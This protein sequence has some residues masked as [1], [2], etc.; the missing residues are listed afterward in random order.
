MGASH[1]VKRGHWGLAWIGAVVKGRVREGHPVRGVKA[2]PGPVIPGRS[3]S[4]GKT[5]DF[6]IICD[7][8]SVFICIL[9]RI[10]SSEV[11][12]RFLGRW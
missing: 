10:P 5:H 3:I 1:E 7:D 2:M 4:P 6:T 8:L 12:F 11:E 9:G